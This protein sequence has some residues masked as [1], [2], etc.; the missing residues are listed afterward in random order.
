[1]SRVYLKTRE[2]TQDFFRQEAAGGV[3]LLLAAIIALLVANSPMAG[4]YNHFLN[5]TMWGHDVAGLH[6]AKSPLHWI[7]DGLMVIFFFLIGLEIKREM[8]EGQLSSFDRAVLPLVAAIGGMA[9][10]ALIFWFINH[11]VPLNLDGWAI[12]AATRTTT[13]PRPCIWPRRF[14]QGLRTYFFRTQKN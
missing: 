14:R 3:L 2:L 7:N 8:V 1:M 10:P 6:L 4:M 9:V 11:D 13:P 12:P 5:G